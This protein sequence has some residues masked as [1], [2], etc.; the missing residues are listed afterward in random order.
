MSDWLYTEGQYHTRGEPDPYSEEHYGLVSKEIVNYIEGT[1]PKFD[2]LFKLSD[3]VKESVFCAAVLLENRIKSGIYKDSIKLKDS[4]KVLADTYFHSVRQRIE[5]TYYPAMS[6]ISDQE[7]ED[8]FSK[9]ENNN[10]VD[11]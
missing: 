11:L 5:S 10:E 9:K 6:S 4:N 2:P 7:I 1:Y 3:N 8:M